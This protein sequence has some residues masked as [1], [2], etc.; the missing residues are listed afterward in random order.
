MSLRTEPEIAEMRQHL[1]SLRRAN[2]MDRSHRWWPAYLFH[3]T[4][5]NNAVS[6]L[7]RGELLSRV[8]AEKSGS[9][10]V[11]IASRDVISQTDP[12][13]KEDVRFYFRPRTPTQ[14][15]NEGF[16]PRQMEELD[17][18]CPV[19]IYFIFDAISVLSQEDSCFTDGNAG[20]VGATPHD[21]VEFFKNIPFK[22]VYHD[23]AFGSGERSQIVYH[24]NAEVMVPNRIG[25]EALQFVGCRS[26]AEY[27]TILHLLPTGTRSRW[28]DKIGV[29]PD[30]RLFYEKWTYVER[31][32]LSRTETIFRFNKNSETQGPFSARLEFSEQATGIRYRWSDQSYI[33]RNSLRVSLVNL[34]YPS[35]YTVRLFLDDHL[36]YANRFQEDDLPF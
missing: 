27:E 24:R 10:Q 11:D 13:R 36:A 16:R 6:I 9:L 14:F 33:C 3:S 12:R 8:E 23:S 29:R 17:S 20:A 4:D 18:H 32:E 22:L 30:L 21:N 1:E 5:I 34:R 28:I 26:T 25:L 31:V 7:R 2:W 35:D 19:P 15:R